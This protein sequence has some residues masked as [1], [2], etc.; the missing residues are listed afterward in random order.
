[1]HSFGIYICCTYTAVLFFKKVN[2]RDWD[3]EDDDGGGGSSGSGGGGG[4][5]NGWFNVA[6]QSWWLACYILIYSFNSLK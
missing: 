4:A 6:L 2:K 3:D 5:I 1:M